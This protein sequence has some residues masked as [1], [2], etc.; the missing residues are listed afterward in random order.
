MTDRPR[1]SCSFDW[2][3]ISGAGPLYT[4]LATQL[5]IYAGCAVCAIIA[6]AMYANNVWQAHNFPFMSQDL[7]FENGAHASP[8]TLV[9]H[10]APPHS[11]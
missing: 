9:P 8:P 3:Y 4:P 10:C 2:S 11:P 5:S 6:C 7:F 1:R